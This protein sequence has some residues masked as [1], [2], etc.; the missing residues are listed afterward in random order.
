M[1][2]AC[3]RI[4][5]KPIPTF[6]RVVMPCYIYIWLFVR[7]PT[8][9]RVGYPNFGFGPERWPGHGINKRNAKADITPRSE[10]LYLPIVTPIV[11][12]VITERTIGF[13]HY[14]PICKYLQTDDHRFTM[15]LAI[16]GYISRL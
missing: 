15:E 2:E 14:I 16:S 13:G 10:S 6:R 8:L 11:I 5:S 1:H 7:S 3:V 12:K 9:F 4:V